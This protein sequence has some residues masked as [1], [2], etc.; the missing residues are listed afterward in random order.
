MLWRFLLHNMKRLL[1]SSFF[2]AGRSILPEVWLAIRLSPSLP[3]PASGSKT[4]CQFTKNQKLEILFFA[5]T[6]THFYRM[7]ALKKMSILECFTFT[8]HTMILVTFLY[9][10][11]HV[12]LCS[13]H[14]YCAFDPRSHILY[15][16]CRNFPS[17]WCE[18]FI[19][20]NHLQEFQTICC[21]MATI[22]S[23]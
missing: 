13:A 23:S 4:I 17:N 21:D 15:I 6:S 8:S 11:Q 2:S 10:L 16:S 22:R 19:I 18:V 3:P 20:F 5:A 1:S 14:W 9:I 7:L 12:P